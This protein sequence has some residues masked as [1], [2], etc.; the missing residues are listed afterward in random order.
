[1]GGLFSNQREVN[2]TALVAMIEDVLVELGHDLD[3]CR[4]D[5][6]GCLRAWRVE[7]GS[8]QV[9]ISL[10]ER[11]DFAHL[12][13]HSTV[14]TLPV[15]CDRLG[16]F[17]HVLTLNSEL[18]GCAFACQGDRILMVADRSTLDLDRSEVLHMVE[19]VKSGADRHDDELAAAFGC[20]LGGQV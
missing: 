12:R 20:L 10:V 4:D 6:P 17:G 9:G 1:M 15:G 5:R 18:S 14:V 11:D 2:T 16:V 13:V 8:A 19:R 3:A 7:K